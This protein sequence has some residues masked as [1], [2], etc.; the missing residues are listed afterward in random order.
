MTDDIEVFQLEK[1]SSE[2]NDDNIEKEDDERN[3]IEMSDD[4][5]SDERYPINKN[6]EEKVTEDTEV[7]KLEKLSSQKNIDNIDE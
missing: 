3:R 1:L 6:D 4:K 5:D 7:L 2:K